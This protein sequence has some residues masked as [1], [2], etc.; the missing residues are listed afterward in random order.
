MPCSRQTAILRLIAL[1]AARTNADDT[2]SLRVGDILA[3][4]IVNIVAEGDLFADL[5]DPQQQPE[6]SDRETVRRRELLKAWMSVRKGAL[7]S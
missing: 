1:W 3:D 7:A 6:V 5:D 2:F 4:N